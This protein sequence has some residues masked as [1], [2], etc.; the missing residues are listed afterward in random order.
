MKRDYLIVLCGVL[1][2]GG[3][4]GSPKG[5]GQS[6]S[7]SVE[8]EAA[9][10]AVIAA[11]ADDDSGQQYGGIKKQYVVKGCQV[12]IFNAGPI[13]MVHEKTG[14]P[15]NAPIPKDHQFSKPTR[16]YQQN[17]CTVTEFAATDGM[18]DAVMDCSKKK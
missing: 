9:A 14:Q 15:C 12:T 4:A 17:G 13:Q 6:N 7:S 11:G 2:L 10:D 3:C 5:V 8:S 18:G 1:L 16:S